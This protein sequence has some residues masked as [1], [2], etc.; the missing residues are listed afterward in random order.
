MSISCKGVSCGLLR[1]Y[2]TGQIW[3][4]LAADHPTGDLPAAL[5]GKVR[6]AR[7]S[8]TGGHRVQG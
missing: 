1:R 8:G 3:G 4:L 6:W 2:N 5:I 7:G